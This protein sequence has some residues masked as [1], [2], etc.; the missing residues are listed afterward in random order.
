MIAIKENVS[1]KLHST[2]RLGGTARYV[3]DITSEEDLLEAL[4][5]AAAHHVPV[6]AIGQGSNIFW[7]DEGFSGLVLCIK[8][9]GFEVLEDGRSV[10][11]GAGVEWDQAVEKS[12]SLGL[13]GLECLS[14]IPGTVGAT[15][16]QNVG[17]YGVEIQNVMQSVR[18]YDTHEKTFVTLTN[19][20]CQFGYRTSRFKAGDSGR[21]ILTKVTFLLQKEPPKPPFYE[22]L[23]A[24]FDSHEI[25]EFTAEVV[26]NAV[27]AIRTSKMPDPKVVANNGSF[28]ANPVIEVPQYTQL[29]E[30]FPAI[31]GW[32]ISDGRIKLAAG[33][34]IEQAGFSDFHDQ[35]TGMATWHLQNLVLINEHATSTQQLFAFKQK[36]VSR[37]YD[38]FGVTLQQEPELLP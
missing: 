33:W 32:P 16:I 22:A 4:A 2:M 13:S 3:C 21:Y 18:A 14:L 31:K 24:Y 12:V 36:I 11:F 29:K 23:Q 38:M 26:R 9:Q 6:R 28:F 5:F 17:A 8:I 19:E 34:L 37:V 35:E 25:K 27:I 20:A 10:A 7:Q 1:L 30:R 15:P